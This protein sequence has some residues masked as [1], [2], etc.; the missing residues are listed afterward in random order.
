M[1]WFMR[2]LLENNGENG[3]WEQSLSELESVYNISRFRLRI[4]CFD[5]DRPVF[6][7]IK[8]NS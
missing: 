7:R 5:H 6:K 1:K 2:I 8:T 4:K 3:T